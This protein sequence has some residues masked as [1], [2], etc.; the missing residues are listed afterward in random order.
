MKS[1]SSPVTSAQAGV[2]VRLEEVVRRHFDSPWRQPLHAPTVNAFERL[3]AMPG[4]D[5]RRP[6]ILDSGCGTGAGTRHIAA[7][8]PER[9]VLGVDR[10]ASRLARLGV[11]EFPHQLDNAWWLRAELPSLWRLAADAGWRLQR[12]YLFYPNPWPK[13]GQLQ[14]RWH[15]H[16]AFPQMLAL[17]GVLEMRCN[18]KVYADEFRRA[19][20]IA[21]PG[22]RVRSESADSEAGWGGIETPFGRK[23]AASGHRLYRVTADLGAAQS[24]G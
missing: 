13:P 16:P 8:F 7:C 20:D 11:S 22:V 15:A 9:Q 5:P 2:H 17:G 14:R 1:A 23:Y 12:H 4:F 21:A 24:T 6:L 3:L 18:W 10:S 19:L